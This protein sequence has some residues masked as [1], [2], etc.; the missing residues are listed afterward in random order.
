MLQ[1]DY[2]L[3]VQQLGI[4]IPITKPAANY[5][6][7][8][9]NGDLLYLSGKGP[10]FSDGVIKE[11]KLGKEFTLKQGYEFAK[12]AC[13]N[14]LSSILSETGN[15][16]SIVQIIEIQGFI[17]CTEDFRDHAKVLDGCSD[18]LISIFGEQGRHARSVFGANSLRDQLPIIIKGIV[19]IK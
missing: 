18:L 8:V 3:K 1:E 14:L 10:H 19:K 12:D 7:A 9:R 17:N 4:S 5:V 11:G 16:S 15:L 6:N 2:D 13:V